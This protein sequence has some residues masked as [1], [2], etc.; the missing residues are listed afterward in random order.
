MVVAN[1]YFVDIKLVALAGENIKNN[2][3]FYVTLA[4]FFP[5]A[6]ASV[7]NGVWHSNYKRVNPVLRVT[8]CLC[9]MLVVYSIFVTIALE[10]DSSS[11]TPASTGF[12]V[13]TLLVVILLNGCSTVLQQS[14]LGIAAKRSTWHTLMYIAGTNVSG[15][16][17]ALITIISILNVNDATWDAMTLFGFTIGLLVLTCFARLIHG[18]KHKKYVPGNRPSDEQMSVNIRG[19]DTARDARMSPG[20]DE[21]M[22]MTEIVK[23]QCGLLKKTWQYQHAIFANFTVTLFCFPGILVKVSQMDSPGIIPGNLFHPIGV[24]LGFNTAAFIGTIVFESKQPSAKTLQAI[25]CIRVLFVAAFMFCNF[26]P[27][28]GTPILF[29]GDATFIILVLLLA[30]SS[31]F[32]T[33]KAFRGLSKSLDNEN[34]KVVASMIASSSLTLGIIVGLM[35]SMGLV[36]VMDQ[37]ACF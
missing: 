34:D 37:N 1:S 19:D 4:A 16:A 20:N 18:I 9:I 13:I 2:F 26:A 31:G 33:A 14:L 24:F 25:A 17:V 28:C 30:G 21:R 27:K 8:A 12:F 15:I 5:K 23:H 32:V 7:I 29:K 10:V 3:I 6:V 36:N 11:S 35:L 22:K